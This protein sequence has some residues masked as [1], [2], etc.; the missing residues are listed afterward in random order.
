[1]TNQVI[2][3]KEKNNRQAPKTEQTLGIPLARAGRSHASERLREKNPE[4]YKEE[5]LDKK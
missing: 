2:D 4:F 5:K 1:M 3:K